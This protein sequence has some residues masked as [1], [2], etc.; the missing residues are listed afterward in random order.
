MPKWFLIVFIAV[1]FVGFLD[2]TYLTIEYYSGVIPPCYIFTGCDQVITSSYGKIAGNVPTSLIGV[3]Y[4][5][6]LFIAAVIF[7]DTKNKRA[8]YILGY[9][10]IAG[11]LVSIRLVYLQ[12]FVIHATC[13]Y[14]M[15]SAVSSTV[16]F[17]AGLYVLKFMKRKI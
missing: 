3:F 5:L 4:Y 15:V 6:L 12:F 14:C 1:S 17:L 8:L 7:I 13:L 10:P 9:L 2:A 11:L 16:L